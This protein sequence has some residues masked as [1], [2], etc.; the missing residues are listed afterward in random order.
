MAS[1]AEMFPFDDVIIDHNTA[2]Q[3]TRRELVV[4]VRGSHERH[5]VQITKN[6]TIFFNSLFNQSVNDM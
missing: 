6:S 5:D 1:N 2:T 4:C 3:Q